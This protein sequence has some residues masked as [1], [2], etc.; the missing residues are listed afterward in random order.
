MPTSGGVS[1]PQS[2]RIQTTYLFSMPFETPELYFVTTGS[3]HSWMFVLT[4]GTYLFNV[5]NGK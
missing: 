5:L 4:S 1:Y 2:V 3:F